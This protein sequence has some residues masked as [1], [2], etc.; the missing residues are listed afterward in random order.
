M[1]NFWKTQGIPHKGWR[2]LDVVDIREDGQSELDTVYEYCIMCG[3]EKIRFVHV[4]IHD[5][6]GLEF[7]VGCI[8]AEKMT[9]DY[10]N[11]EKRESE[12]RNRSKRKLSWNKKTWKI[13]EKGNLVLKYEGH[14]ITI[15]HP[16]NSSQYKVV[17]DETFGN[18]TFKDVAS[19]KN[20][21]FKG[22]EYFKE[23]GKWKKHE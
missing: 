10:V 4:L 23:N 20:A 22:V 16:N 11:P 12:L 14:R 13:N 6:E 21:A 7:R 5:I 9:D 2:L 3:R 1:P 18:K 19:A 8:C 15:F 17:I